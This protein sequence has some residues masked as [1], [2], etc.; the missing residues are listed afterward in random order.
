MTYEQLKADLDAM[1]ALSDEA[2]LD[3]MEVRVNK[4]LRICW[5]SV[6][7]LRK[8]ANWGD[9]E[10][11][12]FGWIGFAD[13]HELLRA[14]ADA[15]ENIW[16]AAAESREQA[17]Q[18]NEE[19]TSNETP[20]DGTF[21]ELVARLTDGLTK[22]A[23]DFVHGVAAVLAEAVPKPAPQTEW[24][25]ITDEIRD[26]RAVLLGSTERDVVDVFVWKSGGGTEAI[27][28]SASGRCI[29]GGEQ[30]FWRWHPAPP[31]PFVLG[32][33]SPSAD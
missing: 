33:R 25:E 1:M 29:Y 23:D 13:G 18:V 24:R 16:R 27:W 11:P 9:T 3:M 31:S 28:R 4:A 12:P 2:F 14:L 10:H 32:I 20:P 5:R 6:A 30:R 17:E 22:V 21:P 19:P 15:R 7:R 26:G 8:L